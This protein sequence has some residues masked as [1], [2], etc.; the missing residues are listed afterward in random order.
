MNI[1][2]IDPHLIEPQRLA[3][4]VMDAIIIEPPVPI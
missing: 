3:G 1:R 4:S 2:D